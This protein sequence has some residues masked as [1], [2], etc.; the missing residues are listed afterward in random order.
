MN[1]KENWKFIITNFIAISA[2]IIS[3]V[4]FLLGRPVN[5]LAYNIEKSELL[6]IEDDKL[7]QVKLV[8]NDSIYQN[9]DIT[10]FHLKN[11]GNTSI[12]STDF[13]GPIKILFDDSVEVLNVKVIHKAPSDLE[14]YPE[15]N[16]NSVLIEG[17]MLNKGYEF[18]IQILSTNSSNIARPS[19]KIL[20]VPQLRPMKDPYE[21]LNQAMFSIALI[22]SIVLGLAS[23]LQNFRLLKEFLAQI[24][25][26]KYVFSKIDYLLVLASA[27][28]FSL[29]FF[30]QSTIYLYNF[31][32]QLTFIILCVIYA[33]IHIIYLLTRIFNAKS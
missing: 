17:M 10:T 8:L 9:I 5:K 19:V 24:N 30:W 16:E 18:G 20:G 14:I 3:V 27:N 2:I 26:L 29:F 7:E 28:F 1:P 33:L 4:L 13:E 11:E 22:G 23:I 12:S 15:I 6:S 25:K 21:I 32:F 31:D